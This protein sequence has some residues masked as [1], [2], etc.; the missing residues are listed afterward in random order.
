VDTALAEALKAP[1]GRWTER[2]ERRYVPK[3]P[4]GAAAPL[5]AALLASLLGALAVAST[6]V[7]VR[8]RQVR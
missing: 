5:G 8:H 1:V 2:W 3:V 6:A 4:L 7:T